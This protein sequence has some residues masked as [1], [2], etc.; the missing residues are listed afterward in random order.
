MTT[1]DAAEQPLSRAR[2]IQL[3]Y[4]AD[5]WG[6]VSLSCAEFRALIDVT[7][8]LAHLALVH[9][10]Y[11]TGNISDEQRALLIACGYGKIAER[12]RLDAR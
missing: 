4:A 11:F 8:L 12:C 9:S 2:I 10:Y 1:T 6:D 3:L 5:K 7:D